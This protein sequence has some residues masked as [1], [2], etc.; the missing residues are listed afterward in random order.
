MVDSFIHT[1]QLFINTHTWAIVLCDKFF[2]FAGGDTTHMSRE[3]ARDRT[4]YEY[5]QRPAW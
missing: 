5:H 1:G 2:F 3:G 4:K